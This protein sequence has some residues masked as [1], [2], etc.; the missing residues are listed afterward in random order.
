MSKEQLHF[1][2]RTILQ[3]MPKVYSSDERLPWRSAPKKRITVDGISCP[4]TKPLSKSLLSPLLSCCTVNNT[5]SS[6]KGSSTCIPTKPL[7]INPITQTDVPHLLLNEEDSEGSGLSCT[8]DTKSC[9]SVMESHIPYKNINN[10]VELLDV[11][12]SPEILRLTREEENY[13]PPFRKFFEKKPKTIPVSGKNC[14]RS[15]DLPE[16]TMCP[17]PLAEPRRIRKCPPDIRLIP[18][19]DQK[20]PALQYPW[21]VNPMIAAQIASVRPESGER[22]YV[23]WFAT[24]E[25]RLFRRSGNGNPFGY[26]WEPAH[27]SWIVPQPSYWRHAANKFF[28][29]KSRGVIIVPAEH[30]GEIYNALEKVASIVFELPQHRDTFLRPTSGYRK[31]ESGVPRYFAFIVDDRSIASRDRKYIKLHLPDDWKKFKWP[32]CPFKIQRWR[33]ALERHP[34]NE[35]VTKVLRGAS[36]GVCYDYDGPRLNPRTCGNLKSEMK[37]QQQLAE[38]REKQL[39]KGIRSGPFLVE[40]ELPLFNFMASPTGG[41]VKTFSKKVRPVNDFGYPYDDSAINENIREE[42]ITN[43]K[44]AMAADVLAALGKN[45]LMCTIDVKG[46]FNL[47]PIA[48]SELHLNGEIHKT[49]DGK[50]LAAFLSVLIFG[51]TSAPRKWHM[52]GE[53]IEF[54][55]RTH[56][57][58]DALIR[59]CDDF[60]IFIRPLPD[61]NP[62]WRRANHVFEQVMRLWTWLGIPFGDFTRPTPRLL[63]LGIDLCSE[64]MCSYVSDQRKRHM[65]EELKRWKSRKSCK[66]RELESLVGSLYFITQVV[67][68]GKAFLGRLIRASC[69]VKGHDHYVCLSRKCPGFA[70]DISWWLDYLPTW[71]GRSVLATSE[72]ANPVDLIEL[73]T[74]ASEEGHGCYWNGHWYGVPWTQKQR[75]DSIRD[76]DQRW[77]T[78]KSK[79]SMPYLELYAI[80]VACATFGHRWSG[81]KVRIWCDCKPAEDALT[82]R[83]S[84]SP[85]SQSLIRI[86]AG[87][88]MSYNF[89]LRVQHIAGVKNVRA[90]LLSHLKFAMFLQDHSADCSATIPS[91]LPAPI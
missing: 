32:R 48:I 18:V 29:D 40:D 4:S 50:T 16:H 82:D 78:K 63:W 12:V 62:D 89:D 53:A 20:M 31:G 9:E 46:A 75:D 47:I 54:M 59:Y 3:N 70:Q 51:A 37:Y 80:A 43:S 88:S 19:E 42:K 7:S 1:Q 56:I 35:F 41:V 11:A 45:T 34:S 67:T 73:E 8:N 57:D 24:S 44:F 83:Y 58:L 76:A 86:I 61:G 22:M 15:L 74:D 91:P 30:G 13:L 85:K 81:H 38:V 87:L 10:D 71:G 49:P 17:E 25:S 77:A 28:K 60:I 39:S 5:Q 26:R 6:D 2:A 14:D 55:T 52:Y 36:W 21:M 90:D 33:K 65:I 84:K 68:W 64:T 23:D 79:R 66:R 72:W 27:W 69:T